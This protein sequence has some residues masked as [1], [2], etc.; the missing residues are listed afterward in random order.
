MN[1]QQLADIPFNAELEDR[2][3]D[4]WCAQVAAL[5]NE[6]TRLLMGL[7]AAKVV[8]SSQAAK[9]G[10]GFVA[11]GEWHKLAEQLQAV[12]EGPAYTAPSVIY[13]AAL[14]VRA[15]SPMGLPGGLGD[16]GGA[17]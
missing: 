8:A 6:C 11:R 5:Q 15:G 3:V 14:E 13:E 9:V 2:T 17:A 7:R 4:E 10:N 16:S 12:I 1:K